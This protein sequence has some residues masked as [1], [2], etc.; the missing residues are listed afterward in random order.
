MAG[1]IVVGTSS[2]A[3][4]GFVAEWYP[5]GMAARARLPWY[6]QRFEA[7]ELNSSFYAVPEPATVARW[8]RETPA[9]FTFHVKLHRALSRHA[10]SLDSLPPGLRD[11][12][13]VGARG[14]VALT[15]ELERALAQSTIDALAP[16]EEAG[17]LGA[18]LLQ[19]SPSFSPRRHEIAELD[20][21]L[22]ELSPRAVAVELRHRGW[23]EGE[24]AQ[25]TIAQL[26][27]RRVAWVGVDAPR[28]EHFTMMPAI[29]AVTQPDFAYLR[30]HGRNAE[31][32]VSGRS[33]A[34]RFGH[35]YS[36]A[37]LGEIVGRARHLARETAIVN[38]M[39]NNNRGADAPASARRTRELLGQDPG[40]EPDA[41][42]GQMRL[43]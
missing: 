6:A 26:S 42:A 1:R 3:D 40:P 22:D 5:Q 25:A 23:V 2:W 31:G 8:A 38:V 14:R 24:R 39:F 34:E 11:G 41:G 9:G 7:V 36:D 43:G 21:L 15:T 20:G 16:L 35:T 27:E 32:Y 17:K 18:L 28:G 19:L 13:Q 12:V 10:A 29:D 4:P 37:E 30:A 33:V